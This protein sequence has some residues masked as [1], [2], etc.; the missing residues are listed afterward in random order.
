MALFLNFEQILI[1][2]L[3]LLFENWVF[4]K[5][6][7]WVSLRGS[8][9]HWDS[10]DFRSGEHFWRSASLGVRGRSH[11]PGQ[12]NFRKFA[13]DF[14]RK[15]LKMHYFSIFFKIFYQ[16]CVNFSRFWNENTNCLENFENILK[17]FDENAIEKL[18]F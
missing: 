5:V 14:V 13:K 2:L 16:A 12:E 11:H 1:R 6:C 9:V 7:I 8:S 15:L 3:F 10:Q 17:I 4:I 18:N